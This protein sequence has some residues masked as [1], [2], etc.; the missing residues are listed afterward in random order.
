MVD[1]EEIQY[2][3]ECPP[4]PESIAARQALIE[5]HDPIRGPAFLSTYV[6]LAEKASRNNELMH[7]LMALV[8]TGQALHRTRIQI[9]AQQQD[10]RIH[11]MIFQKSGTGKGPAFVFAKETAERAGMEMT[12]DTSCTTAGL[13]GTVGKDGDATLGPAY[14]QDIVGFQEASTLFHTAG[15]Q[16]SSDLINIINQITDVGGNISKRLGTGWLRYRS[17]SSLMGTTYPPDSRSEYIGT[18]F[19]PRMGVAYKPV[20]RGFYW[21]VW[22]WL[23]DN[24]NASIS[25]ES[26]A[27]ERVS[28]TLAAIHLK[29]DAG[30]TFKYVDRDEHKQTRI[31]AGKLMHEFDESVAASSEPFIS[32][33]AMYNIKFAMASAAWS[34]RDEVRSEDWKL[35]RTLTIPMW[36]SVLKFIS[37]Y[38]VSVMNRDQQ[39]MYEW[40]SDQIR[41]GQRFVTQRDVFRRFR[42]IPS[43]K[44]RKYLQDL[45]EQGALVQHR[46]VNEKG[47]RPSIQFMRPHSL[48]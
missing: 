24:L 7:T 45:V 4:R 15:Q 26:H 23:G 22:D 37:H 10:A 46:E 36:G 8:L 13:I 28:S 34:L 12:S 42:G 32:R 33:L 35:A 16:H 14:S 3:M 48:D 30:W 44:R 6:E 39:M 18:G 2:P 17:H 1:D 20:G 25:D 11:G 31:E 38:D 40:I 47:G 9:G 21:D 5:K 27:L 29:S 43:D 41:E 19:L